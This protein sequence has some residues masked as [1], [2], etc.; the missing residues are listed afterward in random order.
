M[1]VPSLVF[2]LVTLSIPLHLWMVLDTSL[3]TLIDFQRIIVLF[4]S[5]VLESIVSY[6]VLIEDRLYYGG[7]G[8]KKY[9]IM[10]K[11]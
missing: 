6:N 8:K 1:C 5:A 3:L 2:L 9:K 11:K 7:S 4:L 10:K